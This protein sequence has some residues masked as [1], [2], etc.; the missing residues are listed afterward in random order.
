MRPWAIKGTCVNCRVHQSPGG[1]LANVPG[2][3][4]VL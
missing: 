2:L 1:T 3:A 4:N